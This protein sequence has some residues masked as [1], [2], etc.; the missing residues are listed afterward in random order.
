MN[1]GIEKEVNPKSTINKAKHQFGK[2]STL[3]C[4]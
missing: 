1:L 2:I 3:A 4:P